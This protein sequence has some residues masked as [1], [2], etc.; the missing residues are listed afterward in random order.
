MVK[1]KYGCSQSMAALNIISEV[2]GNAIELGKFWKAL[3]IQNKKYH[4]LTKYAIC[5]LKFKKV[6]N[7]STIYTT[8][9]FSHISFLW[10]RN[11]CENIK[12]SIITVSIGNSNWKIKF[13]QATKWTCNSLKHLARKVKSL[14]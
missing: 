4:F 7:V 12:F 13:T 8:L 6:N 1:T 10:R 2:L 5:L 3:Q 9:Y 14:P 11:A